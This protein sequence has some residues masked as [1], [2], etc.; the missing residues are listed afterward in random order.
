MRRR[1][2]CLLL[3]GLSVPIFAGSSESYPYHLTRT[4]G[5]NSVCWA[6]VTIENSDPKPGDYDSLCPRYW[7][8]SYS[9]PDI[10]GNP[11][12]DYKITIQGGGSDS[13]T[14]EI[15]SAERNLNETDTSTFDCDELDFGRSEYTEFYHSFGFDIIDSIV[16]YWDYNR[17]VKKR[18]SG[19]YR[20]ILHSNHIKIRLKSKTVRD[21]IIF[22][23]E[24]VHFS[25]VDRPF[26]PGKSGRGFTETAEGMGRFTIFNI[27]GQRVSFPVKS[28]QIV[29]IASGLGN[30]GT[31][32]RR[33]L[34]F[35]R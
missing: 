12:Y 19:P 10:F 29:I 11:L 30:R 2:L 28:S 25:H 8:I 26:I 27:H 21:S 32:P 17:P 5:R 14:L 18:A 1:M 6:Q 20:E 23:R 34:L 3:S 13:G 24:Y 9:Q 4:I 7:Y 22:T 16:Y 35:G 31:V 15:F 33:F